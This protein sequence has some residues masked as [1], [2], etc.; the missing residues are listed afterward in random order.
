MT[1]TAIPSTS[2]SLQ[3]NK[4]NSIAMHEDT[5]VL[6]C[7]LLAFLENKLSSITG[8]GPGTLPGSGTLAVDVFVGGNDDGPQMKLVAYCMGVHLLL[9]DQQGNVYMRVQSKQMSPAVLT[10]SECHASAEPFP[11][12]LSPLPS[13]LAAELYVSLAVLSSLPLLPVLPQPYSS[14]GL[15]LTHRISSKWVCAL[16]SRCFLSNSVDDLLSATTRD[17]VAQ[18]AQFPRYGVL[19]IGNHFDH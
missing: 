14:V 5:I 11:L 10:L 19:T 12:M 16:L 15:F 3:N 2:L 1:Y 8:R 17:T 6:I 13:Q 7:N 4:D 18:L 9:F